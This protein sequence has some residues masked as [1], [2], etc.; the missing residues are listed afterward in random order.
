MSPEQ[1]AAAYRSAFRHDAPASVLKLDGLTPYDFATVA[2]KAPLLT[3]RDPKQIAKWLEDEALAK[4]D[5]R[6]QRIGF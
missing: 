5:A 2:R 6:Q 3:E 4:A 1:I